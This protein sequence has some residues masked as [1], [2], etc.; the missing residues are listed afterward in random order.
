MSR[1]A[2]R[3][4][5]RS[6]TV[7]CSGDRR[8]RRPLRHGQVEHLQG[9]RRRART[10]LPRH[11][12]AV[13]GDDVVDAEQRRR[14]RRPGRGGRSP[15]ASRSSSPAPTRPARPSRSTGRTPPGPI[16]TAEVTAAVSAVSAVPEV[17]PAT[18]RAAARR[19]RRARTGGIVVEGRDIGTTVLPDATLKIFLTASAEARAARRSGELMGAQSR[20]RHPGGADPAGRGRLRPQDLAAGQGGRRGRGGHHASSPSTRSSS[21]IVALVEEKRAAR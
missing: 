19:G 6:R 8:H 12:R 11:R 18:G 10:Q 21:R 13:P 20:G 15:P 4:R 14:R 7:E 3:A 1:T 9:G 5:G 17:R 2:V 16:R